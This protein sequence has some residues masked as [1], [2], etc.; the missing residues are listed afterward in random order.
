MA[1]YCAHYGVHHY[2]PLRRETKI[3]Q[4]RKVTVDKPVFSGYVFADMDRPQRDVVVRSGH[5]VRAIDVAD[6]AVFA[7][8]IE[9]VRLALAVDPT[10]GATQAI[11]RGRAV[12]I[13][14]GPFQGL[15]GVV[16]GVH[17]MSRV[18]LNVDMIGQGVRLDVELDMLERLD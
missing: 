11:E 15:E 9:Q 10:L 8:E 3:Y 1:D 18:V 5:L 2:L 14:A 7:K 4:R 13:V 16:E 6:Q 17:A 12:R